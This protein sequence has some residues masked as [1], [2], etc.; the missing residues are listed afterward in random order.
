MNKII[1][2]DIDLILNNNNINWEKFKNKTILIT[3]AYGMLV[4]YMTFTLLRLSE[5]KPEF[6]TKIIAF[7]RNKKKAKKR[8][9]YFI[10]NSNLELIEH[11]LLSAKEISGDI[12][13][14]IHGA[15]YANS[16]YFV[17][18][19]VS[20]I[21]PNVLGTYYLLELAKSKKVE[22]FLFFS[23]GAVYGKNTISE[24]VNEKDYGYLD[25]IQVISCYG[26]S[27]RMAEN[28]CK[29]WNYQ[30]G[31][32]VK[33]IRPA[34]IYGPTMDIKNDDRVFANFVNNLIND[35]NIVIKSDG[36]AKRSF[37]YISDATLAFFKVLLEGNNGESYNIGNDEEYKSIKE[38]AEI[39]SDT[40][41]EKKIKVIIEN[42]RSNSE[43]EK[44]LMIS[45]KVEAL[46]WRCLVPLRNGIERTVKSYL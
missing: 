36:S 20:V 28:M 14:I 38:L 16:G 43:E 34:H 22:S 8:F 2:E 4:S 41:P 6:N 1:I 27:K 9:G 17:N 26:E 32:P 23:S 37:C 30:Y 40:F 7:I 5:L 13:Y 18:D 19:P 42:K 31:I 45:S 35:Q 12:D 39:F 11:D 46:G 15:S 10:N 3:G 21:T 29:C 25:P 24:F 33:M 44:M